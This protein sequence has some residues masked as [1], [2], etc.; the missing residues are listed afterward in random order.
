[1]RADEGDICVNRPKYHKLK[2]VKLSIA[3]WKLKHTE[4]TD[5]RFEISIQ[6]L[7]GITETLARE[8]EK[9]CWPVSTMKHVHRVLSLGLSKCTL[10]DVIAQ[11]LQ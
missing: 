6:K 3:D 5:S 10:F 9:K 7:H 11:K 4:K 8:N 1:M 2:N